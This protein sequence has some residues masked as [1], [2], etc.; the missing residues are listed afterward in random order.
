M[1]LNLTD[2][3]GKIAAVTGAGQGVGR[4][5][6]LHFAR[7]GARAVIVNDFYAERAQA[8][9]QEIAALGVKAVAAVCDVTDQTQVK[10]AFAQAAHEAGGSIDILVNN[11]GNSGVNP[12][13]EARKHFWEVGEAAWDSFIR[14]NFYGVINC[15]AAVVPGM[16]EKNAGRLITIISDAGRVGEPNLE[17]YSGAKAGA[18]GFMRGTARALGRHNIT[19]NCVAISATAT[20]AI[21]ARLEADPDRTKKMLSNYVIRRVGQ[22]EDVANM[23]LFLASD[24][25]SWITGQTYPVNGGFSFNL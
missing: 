7:S 1:T 14:V 18:A 8:V 25:S 20:P 3:D 11:A 12:D 24:S 10:A 23:V 13:P 17:I 4:E 15:T 21:A 16:I 9:V 2:L 22:P 6:A 5:V 19:A